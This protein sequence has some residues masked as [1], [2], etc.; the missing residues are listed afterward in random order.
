M[1]HINT[2]NQVADILTKSLGKFKFQ[3]FIN[4]MGV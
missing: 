4:M 1:K 2:E 3:K